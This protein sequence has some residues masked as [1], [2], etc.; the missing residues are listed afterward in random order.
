[1]TLIRHLTVRTSH[2]WLLVWR[3]MKLQLLFAVCTLF[4]TSH[5]VVLHFSENWLWDFSFQSLSSSADGDYSTVQYQ[6]VKIQIKVIQPNVLTVTKDRR[7]KVKTRRDVKMKRAG[8]KEGIEDRGEGKKK[9]HGIKKE[10]FSVSFKFIFSANNRKCVGRW[11]LMK[12]TLSLWI[13]VVG[14]VIVQCIKLHSV[15]D[16]CHSVSCSFNQTPFKKQAF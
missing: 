12:V 8:K 14:R 6:Y 1:M 3:W 7:L 11:K 15:G 5:F 4:K 2:S 10:T 13:G 16:G 9:T